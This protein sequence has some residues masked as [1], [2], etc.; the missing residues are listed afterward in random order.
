MAILRN[1]TA[2]M[3]NFRYVQNTYYR[4]IYTG[5]LVANSTA[6]INSAVAATSHAIFF[7]LSV[8]LTLMM[9]IIIYKTIVYSYLFDE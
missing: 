5:V 9:S 6:R 4:S 2:A 1:S 7:R 8:Q 3:T